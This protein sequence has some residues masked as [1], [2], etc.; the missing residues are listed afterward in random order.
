MKKDTGK[1]IVV[2]YVP[3]LNATKR[4]LKTPSE[5]YTPEH[6]TKIAEEIGGTLENTPHVPVRACLWL[7]DN[8]SEKP[9]FHPV[10]LIDNAMEVLDHLKY[11]CEND[12]ATWFHL[13]LEKVDDN[14]Y[15]V[16][17]FPNL[18]KS[19]ERFKL[20]CLVYTDVVPQSEADYT[21]IFKPLEF[22]SQSA[23]MFDNVKE[24]LGE[25]LKIGFLNANEFDQSA[26]EAC[27]DKVQYIGPISR[28][29]KDNAK[30]KNSYIPPY[31]ESRL[32]DIAENDE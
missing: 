17:L 7:Q 12:P 16:L 27:L 30:D 26:P 14:R 20:A 8:T 2:S 10:F 22:L 18:D 13:Y 3:L 4:I 29:R 28:V 15:I 32:K 11:W 25:E 9:E 31:V 5:Q 24:H 19:I 6:A 1:Y 21:L 23:T